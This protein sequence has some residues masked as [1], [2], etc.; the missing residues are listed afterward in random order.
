M[1]LATRIVGGLLAFTAMAHAAT[2]ATF[3]VIESGHLGGAA[4]AQTGSEEEEP[5]RIEI[6]AEAQHM[7]VDLAG[8]RHSILYS[9]DQGIVW[10]LD[11]ERRTVLELDRSTAT[12]AAARLR[13]VE[14]ELRARTADLPP[15]AR[16]AARGLLDSAFGPE[17]LARPTLELRETPEEGEVRGIPC[18]V[19]ELHVDGALTARFC[20]AR[21]EDAGLPAEALAPVRSL[22]AFARDVS[23]LM[24]KRLHS[25]G[26]A[27]LD[28][29]DRV[30]GVPLRIRTYEGEQAT[31]EAVV[32]EVVQSEAPEGSFQVPEGY[33]SDIAIRVRER[34]GGP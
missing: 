13:G 12:G 28:L 20:E 34:L 24:P 19:H 26:L 6:W 22:S 4:S 31:R 1:R 5:D 23:P 25:S 29:F 27:A 17:S 21:L 11:H 2:A 10:A 33:R 32:T 18:R 3:V 7:R 16:Q 30:E 15:E 8:G 14:A 9:V